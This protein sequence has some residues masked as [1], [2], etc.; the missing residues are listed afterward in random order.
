MRLNKQMREE[1]LEAFHAELFV[2][3]LDANTKQLRKLTL[4]IYA[5][6][7][8][9]ETQNL[10]KQLPPEL[11]RT[12]INV[13]PSVTRL[14]STVDGEKIEKVNLRETTSERFNPI[15]LD[16]P[17]FVPCSH[18]SIQDDDI[19]KQA[20]E[21][22]DARNTLLEKKAQ[23]MTAL[24]AIIKTA[25]TTEDLLRIWPEGVELSK[26][27]KEITERTA[28]KTTPLSVPLP[29]LLLTEAFTKE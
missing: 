24:G 19:F 5:R 12:Q 4:E 7:V 13:Y 14:V 3:Q 28:E 22:V 16:F 2:K 26:K 1:L 9:P 8:P 20:S 27:F 11:L 10:C 23:A 21:L 17:I 6:L 25:K 18:F 15:H 29:A